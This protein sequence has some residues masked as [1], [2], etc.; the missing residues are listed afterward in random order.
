MRRLLVLLLL[1]PGLVFARAQSQPP[2][3]PASQPPS[4]SQPPAAL[5]LSPQAA[6]DQAVRPLDI[7]RR[8]AQN[9]S[10]SELAAL[11]VAQD[12][13]SASCL[14]RTPD[15]FTGEDLLAYARLCA[16]AQQWPQVKRAGTDYLIAHN[17]AKPQDKLTGFPNLSLAFDYVIQASLHLNDPA[18]AFGT[19]QTMLWTVPYDDLTSEAINATVLYVQLIHTDEAIALLA[20]RQPLLLALLKA[21]AAPSA[22]QAQSA[23]PPLTIHDL[24]ADAIALP[25]MQQFDDDPI[26]AASAFVE[27]EAAV[28]A[29]LLPD[30]A[31]LTAGLRRQYLLL[32]SPLP[33][34]PASAWLLNPSFAV[35]ADLNTKFGA[36][37]IF[38]LFP[39]WCAQC[40]TVGQNFTAAATRLNKSGI[41]FYA[42]LSQ[43]DPHPPVP[44]EAPKLPLKP[45]TPGGAKAGKPATAA[46]KPETPHADIQISVKPIPAAILMGTPT[47]IVPLE[48][49]NTFV[50]TDFPLI[51]ATDHDGIVRYIRPAPDNA[52][53]TGG[54]MDQIADRILEQWPAPKPQ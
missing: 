8:A 27:L 12:L 2:A 18:N 36:G 33:N 30:N 16:F 1:C 45:S 35:P 10:D 44:K 43:A 54:L 7:V 6:Y 53:V 31:I 41:Y 26:A 39:D 13:A 17:V 50:A 51:I 29:N 3:Q 38:F 47:L 9:W 49:M 28:P 46:A 14:A 52:L 4:P 21:H 24:Y 22:I 42:L 37:S 11:A 34:I 19:A 32:G 5:Q 15:Q 20:E 40:V 25:A 23:H 48:T